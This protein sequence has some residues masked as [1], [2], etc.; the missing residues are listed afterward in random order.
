VH[1]LFFSPI[2]YTF[3]SKLLK[4]VFKMKFLK[5]VLVSSVIASMA[6]LCSCNKSADKKSASDVSNDSTA[7]EAVEAVPSV[8]P[9]HTLEVVYMD[10]DTVL[11]NYTLAKEL[12]AQLK[13]KQE[14][15]ANSLQNK[16][17]KLQQ[18]MAQYQKEAAQFQQDYQNGK[19]LTQASI[20]EAQQKFMK[21][22]QELMKQ[23]Q[24][25]QAL[26]QKLTNE[27]L[28]EQEKMNKR[29]RDSLDSVLKQY[30]KEN[31]YRLILSNNG[32]DN[33]IWGDSSLN[34]TKI[35]TNDLNARYQ[36]K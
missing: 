20:Q 14:K 2:F 29:L 17:T 36:K 10:V 11:Q 31:R 13:S 32:R 34:I 24:D 23:D 19:F 22:E 3:E 15:S 12:T 5:P 33:V 1:F 4:Y 28:D 30:Q 9:S 18:D 16:Q 21:R 8:A 25:L 7:V 6:F 27:M 35:V 26:N